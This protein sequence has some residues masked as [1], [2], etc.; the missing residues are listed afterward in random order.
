MGIRR[1]RQED[2][3]AM[4]E[5]YTPYVERTT[6]S[7]EYEAPRYEAF[8]NRFLEHTAQFPWLVWEEE[9]T[10]LG[11]AYAG[12]AFERAAY[13]W[14]AET[15]VYLAKE[16]QGRGWGRKLMEALEKILQSQGYRVLY[17]LITEENESSLRFHEALGF[18]QAACLPNCG[19]KQGRW[20]G[21]CYLEK[22]LAQ[23][24]QP[25]NFPKS[26]L[27]LGALL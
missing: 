4:L 1:A 23:P 9:G 25:E 19:Y 20:I 12:A 16:A 7:F 21:V 8:R 2:I 3:P 10:V 14:C 17:A 6:V 24:G 15:S 13:R 26:W 27:E 18:A 22:R 5:I 11:Y